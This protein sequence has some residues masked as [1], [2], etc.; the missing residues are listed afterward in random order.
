MMIVVWW[1]WWSQLPK[2]LTISPFMWILRQAQVVSRKSCKVCCCTRLSLWSHSFLF[3]TTSFGKA[4]A[5][6]QKQSFLYFRCNFSVDWSNRLLLCDV[7][8]SLS[9]YVSLSQS[10]FLWLSSFFIFSLSSFSFSR[11]HS[12]TVHWLMVA[13]KAKN[14]E[15]M[16]WRFEWLCISQLTSHP[17][18][19]NKI[20]GILY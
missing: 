3:S 11:P 12:T 17:E 13:K 5:I 4:E 8:F 18:C 16:T 6:V 9:V 1:W 14:H 2:L 19:R 10:I 7:G 20:A 15:K